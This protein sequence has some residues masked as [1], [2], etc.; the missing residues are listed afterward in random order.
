MFVGAAGGSRRATVLAAALSSLGC[1]FV[2]PSAANAVTFTVNSTADEA[3]AA[4]NGTCFAAVTEKCTLRAAIEEANPTSTNDIVNFEASIFDGS[5]AGEIALNSGLPKIVNPIR[6]RGACVP[7]GGS[8]RPCVGIEG[9]SSE[10][11]L[12]IENAAGVQIDG[13]AITGAQTGIAMKNAASFRLRTTWLGAK[14]DGSIDGNATGFF[15]GPGSGGQVGSE[16]PGFGNVFADS[17]GDGLQLEGVAGTTVLGNYFGVAPDGVT[18]AGNGEDIEIASVSGSPA[19]GNSI[20]T[21]VSAAAAATPAC[22]GGC[23]VISGAGSNGIDLQGDGGSEEPAQATTVRGNY[24]GLNASG[25]AAIPNSGTG[26]LVGGAEQTVI[27]GPKVEE[28]NRINGGSVAVLAGP[29]A[30]DL[31][32]HGNRIGADSAGTGILDPPEEGIAVD[33]EGLTS[34]AVEAAI[35]DNQIRM[36]SGV[37]I[38]QQGFGA[39]IADNEVDGAETGIEVFGETEEHGNLIEGNSLEGP[40]ENGIIVASSFNEIVGNEVFGAGEAGVLIEGEAPSGVTGNVVGGNA[41]ADENVITGS[42]GDAIE[43]VDVENTDN[44]I[45][46]NRGIVNGGL[47]IE[48]VALSEVEPKWPNHGIEPPTFATS[49][50]GSSGTAEAGAR[51][52]V[53][54]KQAAEAGELD[55]FL[56]EAIADPSGEWEVAYGN[57]L[58]SGAI[59]AAT[60]TSALGGTSELATATV[61]TESGG[62]GGGGGGGAG[63]AGATALAS[64]AGDLTAPETAIL[65]APKKK[66]HGDTARFEFDSDEV[67]TTFQCKLDDKQFKACKSPK[68]YG[69]LRSGKHVFRV[70]AVDSAGN[71]DPSPA[72]RKFTVLDGGAR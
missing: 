45:A 6:I 37:A 33:S 56:G 26:I 63:G 4:V 66:I 41:A 52:R 64:T 22:D 15:A 7:S 57:S 43:I 16:G 61:A 38:S 25:N 12:A 31:V 21:K 70:R 62:G 1:T 2:A 30:G 72:K 23:N 51:V 13:L 44:E 11:A 29:G 10:A 19:T 60:Q 36:E 18:P 58:P 71:V 32:V 68:K 67:G 39:R 53:F 47:F 59:V 48:L 40:G 46:R 55:S 27:G 34:P 20:G 14:L 17:S 50:T 3:D 35:V 65:K 24:V 5:A 9:K 54:R 8:L 42:A 49:A 28:A 69:G